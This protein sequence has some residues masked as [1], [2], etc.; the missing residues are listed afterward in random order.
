VKYTTELLLRRV[1]EDMQQRAE[2]LEAVELLIDSSPVDR[3]RTLTELRAHLLDVLTR[4]YP[5]ES[6]NG[7]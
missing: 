2:I 5:P 1:A 4:D 6:R 7:G 3:W